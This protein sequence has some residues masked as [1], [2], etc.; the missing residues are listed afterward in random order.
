M[1][2]RS[3]KNL[4][5]L[6][7]LGFDTRTGETGFKKGGAAKKFADGGRVQDDGRPVK[8]PKKAPSSPV[9]TNRLS[10]TFKKGGSVQRKQAGGSAQSERESKG[11]R[12]TYATQ[13]AEN[14]KD[15]EDLKR[16]TNPMTYIQPVIDA[17]KRLPGAVTEM[18]KSKT[19]VPAKKSGGRAF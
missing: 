4:R 19:V 15:V 8:M 14:L 16:V 18:V 6:K 3:Y 17:A 7:A 13:K 11:Y 1:L 2:F 12:D 5:K 9:S 10:G